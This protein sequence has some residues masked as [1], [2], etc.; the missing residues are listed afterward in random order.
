MALT[1][2]L[3]AAGAALTVWYLA[4]LVAT[5]IVRRGLTP[6]ELA[7]AQMEEDRRLQRRAPLAER[8]SRK[9]RDHGW[10]GDLRLLGYLAV[11]L[12]MAASL[13]VSVV[14]GTGPVAVVVGG[15]AVGVGAFLVSTRLRFRR[16][17]A[18]DRQLLRMFTMLAAQIEA[19]SGPQHAL[20]IIL[21]G[22]DDPLRT[23]MRAVLD[24]A[25]TNRDLVSATRRLAQR[26]PS[27][28]M[29]LYLASLEMTQEM[30][31]PIA[32]ALRRAAE[33]LSG[34]FEL[35][36]EAKAELAQQRGEFYGVFIIICLIALMTLRGLPGGVGAVFTN[37]IALGVFGF[38]AGNM[39]LGAWR[40]SRA[41]RSAQE[42]L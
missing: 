40:A 39:A 22:L 35:I 37:P 5:V 10:D 41:I 23:E 27:R 16:K 1:Q 24:E 28:A 31:V 32:P 3:V 38:A 14:V 4:Q 13:L 33:I 21:G 20:E 19:G 34:D 25:A 11:V 7:A 15:L 29:D 26:Y 18:F 12:W 9:L 17:Q 6:L 36:A 30:G 2:V 42:E 8:I